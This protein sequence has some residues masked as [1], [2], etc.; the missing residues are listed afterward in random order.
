MQ[1]SIKVHSRL[2][3][4]SSPKV[5]AIVNVTPDSFYTSWGGNHKCFDCW[6]VFSYGSSGQMPRDGK[7][8]FDT[9]KSMQT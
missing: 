6:V 3:D 4:L 9:D 1:Q 5:M 7:D 8:T 2:L